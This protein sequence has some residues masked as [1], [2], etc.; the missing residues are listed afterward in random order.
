MKTHR[1]TFLLFGLWANGYCLGLERA[2]EFSWQVVLLIGFS[3]TYLITLVN[4]WLEEK[5]EKR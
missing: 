4:V 3:A 1:S 2:N 5:E